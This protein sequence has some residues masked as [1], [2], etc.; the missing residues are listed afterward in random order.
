MYFLKPAS[1][2]FSLALALGTVQSSLL[3][4]QQSPPTA[5]LTP[6]DDL[7]RA[8]QRNL[9]HLIE[10]R[11]FDEALSILQEKMRTNEVSIS[12]ARDWVTVLSH[13]GRRPEARAFLQ[14]HATSDNPELRTWATQ[15]LTVLERL[16]LTEDA[17]ARYAK[18]VLLMRDN[19]PGEAEPLLRGL[20]ETEADNL[21]VHL[22]LAQCLWA[23]GSLESSEVIDGAIQRFGMKPELALWQGETLLLR[24]QAKKAVTA[25]ERA[26]TLN[27]ASER[28]A[29]GLAKAHVGSGNKRLAIVALRTDTEKNP[30]H[31]RA[32]IEL[33][34]LS[35]ADQQR[36][37]RLAASRA[38]HY[39]DSLLAHEGD[40]AYPESADTIQRNIELAIKG[41]GT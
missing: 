31:V 28:A 15:R 4:A 10:Q 12:L 9:R 6:L 33:S 35:F 14:T 7:M 13:L 38:V 18:S 11:N 5:P 25:F 22:R 19:R 3:W 2:L 23:L 40:L 39:S 27:P 29:L 24:R 41:P 26:V 37:I 21:A 16:F 8:T 1:R 20:V 32:L 17:R 36:S 34:K 30:N